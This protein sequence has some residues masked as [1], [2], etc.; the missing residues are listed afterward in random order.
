MQALIYIFIALAALAV[1][2]MA[3]FG[4]AFTPVE[5][6][7]AVLVFAGA[8]M[9]VQ[10]RML[11]QRAE[12]RLEKAIEELSRLLSTDAQAG[13]TLSKRVNELAD[14]NAGKRLEIV[15]ADISVLGTVIR[16]VA[17]AVAELEEKQRN[18]G[19]RQQRASARQ[20]DGR[21][22]DPR[23]AP[24][25]VRRALAANRLSH[26]MRPILAL[27]QRRVVGHD[28]VARLRL[29]DDELAERDAF[30]PREG[31]EDILRQVDAAALL[32]AITL[33]RRSR[34][35]GQK[36]NLFVPV[37]RATLTDKAAAEQHLANIEANE[38]IAQR[39]HFV[40]DEAEWQAL[41]SSV[42]AERF[43]K[44]GAAFALDAVT[45]LRGDM[46]ALAA[47]GV[48]FL[49]IEAGALLADPQH[50]TDFHLSDIASYLARFGIEL[51]ASGISSEREI[52][53]LLEDGI[54]LVQGPYLSSPAPAE[55]DTVAARPQLRR[56]QG[57]A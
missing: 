33:G 44:A 37:S 12:R 52:V 14:Q 15:E 45:S 42:L 36:P 7:L 57:Q 1:G 17:E 4:L 8:A 43:V 38:A 27:P 34:T 30:L 19:A 10:E 28:L 41:G 23:I 11:R 51:I 39:L 56:A 5:A 29:D 22:E 3:Y 49:R 18:P 50:F 47:H 16:Q 26:Y 54:T 13:A 53:E 9:L 20:A 46:S 25:T 48:K 2:A 32:E 31:H 35:N 6:I 55:A 21:E 24:E 40:M